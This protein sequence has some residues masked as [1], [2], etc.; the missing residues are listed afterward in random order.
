MSS[1]TNKFITDVCRDVAELPDR[2]SPADNPDMMLVTADELEQI[3]RKRLTLAGLEALAEQ[4]E[5]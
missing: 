1:A 5:H 4:T 2:T 3:L